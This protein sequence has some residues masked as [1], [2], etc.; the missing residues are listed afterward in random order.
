MV[1][2]SNQTDRKKNT[3]TEIKARRCKKIIPTLF[4]PEEHHLQ[5][6][7]ANTAIAIL[8]VEMETKLKRVRRVDYQITATMSP[9]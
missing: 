9:Q 7:S 5:A 8:T 1:N 6:D 3:H 4:F 2:K